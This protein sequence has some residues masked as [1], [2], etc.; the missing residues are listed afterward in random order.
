MLPRPVWLRSGPPDPLAHHGQLVEGSHPPLPPLTCCQVDP[1]HLLPSA[2][3][4][5]EIIPSGH[6]L[7]S[8]NF[9]ATCPPQF[10]QTSL[11]LYWPT[12]LGTDTSVLAEEITT[13]GHYPST[14]SPPEFSVT[15]LSLYWPTDLGTDTRVLAEEITTSGHYPSTSSPPEFSITSLSL[16]WHTDLN[17]GTD[18]LA[19]AKEI[20]QV[21][22]LTYSFHST[23]SWGVF[24]AQKSS[25]Q[26]STFSQLHLSTS[27]WILISQNLTTDLS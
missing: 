14:S 6:S 9:T 24:L 15:S 7:L 10:P 5:K 3:A 21:R 27:S 20:I 16:Y 11:S 23:L 22:Q 26:A 8:L 2:P 19:K 1:C 13:S 25:C 12:D 4:A 17:T 18:V